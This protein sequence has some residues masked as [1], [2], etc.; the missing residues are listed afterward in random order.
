MIR[1]TV[2]GILVV[3]GSLQA[4]DITSLL[5]DAQTR[6]QES[7]YEQALKLYKQAHD[8]AGA[9]A[10]VEY[11]IGLCH[12]RLGDGDKAV[13]HFE[14]VA[15]RTE[16]PSSVRRAAFFNLGVV[17]ATAARQRLEQLLAPE[18]EENEQVPPP[19]PDAPENIEELQGIAAELLGAI[20]LFREVESIAPGEEAQHNMRAVRITRRN[21]LGL[22]KNAIEAKEKGDMLKDP[23]AYLEA[24]IG[25]QRT[26][27]GLTRHLILDPGESPTAPRQARRAILRLQRQI[28]ERT[29]TFANHLAQFVESAEQTQA[30]P[31]EG[32]ETPREQVYHAAAGQLEKSIEA[33]RDAAAF[34]MDGEIG[35]SF[36]EQAAALD[37]MYVAL[38]LFPQ[39]PQKALIKARMEQSR[40]REMVSS[41]QSD[42][43]WMRDA[44]LG[45]VPIPEGARIAP[46][47]TALYYDQSQVSTALSVLRGQCERIAAAGPPEEEAGMAAQEAPP[48]MNP[49]LNRQLADVLAAS[50]ALRFQCLDAVEAREKDETLS[51]QQE[52]LDVIDAALDLLPK[53]IEQRI[54]ELVVRQARLNE[55]VKAETGDSLNPAAQEADAGLDEL[56]RLAAQARSDVLSGTPA[57]VAE[58]IRTAQDGIHVETESVHEDLRAQI[59]TGGSG[60]TGPSGPAGDGQSAQVQA[61][62]EAGKH[63]EQADFEMLVAVEGLDKAI[64]QN[65]LGPME[66]E[67]PVQAAQAKALEELVKALSALRPPEDQPQCD[68]QEPQE[69]PQPQEEEDQGREN[70]RRAVERTEQEREQAERQLYQRRPRTVIKDW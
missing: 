28:L 8:Q 27:V 13:Q 39:E 32:E 64:V 55:E 57:E 10:S 66:A 67:G 17:R 31:A 5:V 40:L 11:N 21:V 59:P 65:T 44:L 36:D 20:A 42:S 9:D 54:A 22:L 35:Q 4:A 37:E 29:G 47:K 3:G 58:R 63:V 52:I 56:R 50:D 45:D 19:P 46:A 2:G 23:P 41:I 61:Y 60:A 1:L 53:T 18:T 69:Q 70:A 15:S 68:Q 33:Q 49:E 25:Q 24:L 14:R 34:M 26:T 12:L 6:F 38:R 43:D 16:A 62:I 48:Q 51:K 30:S 7:H